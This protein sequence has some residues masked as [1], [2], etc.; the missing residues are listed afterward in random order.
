MNIDQLSPRLVLQLMKDGVVAVDEKG[1]KLLMLINELGSIL[2]A[3]KKLDIPYSHAWEYISRMERNLGFK[4]IESKRGGKGGGGTTLTHD[5]Y[6]LVNKYLYEYKRHFNRELEIGETA[7]SLESNILTY[8]GSN[9]IV[10]EHLFGVLRDKKIP[11]DIHWIGSLRGIA[12]ILLD[13]CDLAGVHLLDL[14]TGEYNVGYVRKYAPTEDIVLVRGYE[15]EIGFISREKMS[16]EEVIEAIF[17]RELKIIN[18][19]RGSG[20]RIL[21]EDIIK[22]EATKRGI[23]VDKIEK[24]VKGY[25][26]TVYTH[27]DTARKIALGEA[28]VGVG[29]KTASQLY[30]LNFIHITWEKFDFITKREKLLSNP[31]REFVE[32]LKSR[33]V[34]RIIHSYEGYKAGKEIGETIKS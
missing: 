4:I 20:T 23:D 31:I 18:R 33:D 26:E 7:V 14:E 19:N 10:L 2:I 32:T 34:N 22:R 29:L 6:R 30:K 27:I 5:G 17:N 11:V 9:D 8:A 15:R 3:S 13:E 28:D 24:L 21:T 16:Y 1:I 25:S 12:S